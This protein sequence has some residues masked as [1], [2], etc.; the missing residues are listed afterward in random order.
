M[1]QTQTKTE[2]AP[3]SGQQFTIG[4]LDNKP[5]LYSSRGVVAV[6]EAGYEQ[7]RH[8]DAKNIARMLNSHDELVGALEELL[9]VQ[10]CPLGQS[11][12]DRWSVACNQARAALARAE[13]GEE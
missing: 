7:T 3:A 11:K 9:A 1:K 8:Q 5:A 6:F 12:A 13:R 10:V 4:V 2:A